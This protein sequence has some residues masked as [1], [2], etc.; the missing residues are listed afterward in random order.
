MFDL[1]CKVCCFQATCAGAQAT[2]QSSMA[3]DPSPRLVVSYK[4]P[5]ASS[6]HTTTSL[7]SSTFSLDILHSAFI[8]TNHYHLPPPPPATQPMPISLVVL[9]CC[10]GGGS[11]FFGGGGGSGG[12]GLV[13]VLNK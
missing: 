8:L 1:T 10:C 3:T 12:G 13:V 7:L 6:Y 4:L 9:F 2:G 11:G 5:S